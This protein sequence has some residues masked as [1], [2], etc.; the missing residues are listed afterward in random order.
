MILWVEFVGSL[1]GQSAIRVSNKYPQKKLEIF[2]IGTASYVSP[3]RHIFEIRVNEENVIESI[4]DFRNGK[5]DE[6]VAYAT[7][8]VRWAEVG[9]EVPYDMW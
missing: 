5:F 7:N 4:Y 9:E 8:P 1:N 2:D 6:N 3:N